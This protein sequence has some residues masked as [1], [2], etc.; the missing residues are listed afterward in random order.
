VYFDH[1]NVLAKG[2]WDPSRAMKVWR[3]KEESLPGSRGVARAALEGASHDELLAELLQT[4]AEDHIADRF[5]VWIESA[6]SA[7]ANDSSS[8]R[9]AVQ[10]RDRQATPAEWARLS[11]EAA[12]PPELL[13]SGKSFDQDL[14]SSSVSPLIGPLVEMRHALWVPVARNGRLRGVLLAATRGKNRGLPRARLEEA[15]AQ[16]ELALELEEQQRIARERSADTSLTRRVLAALS[17]GSSADALLANLAE[18]CTD[19]AASNASIGAVFAVIGV[20]ALSPGENLPEGEMQFRW[21]SGDESWTRALE[22][23]PLAA[24]WRKSLMER[25]VLGCS[26]EASWGNEEVGRVVAIPVETD[27]A[28][29][30]LLVAGLRPGAA[31]LALLERL[32]LSGTLA[33][34]ALAHFTRRQEEKQNANW[35]QALLELGSEAAVLLDSRGQVF[36]MNRAARKLL[37]ES[38]RQEQSGELSSHEGEYFAQLFRARDHEKIK[39]WSQRTLRGAPEGQLPSHNPLEVELSNGTQVR[40]RTATPA[41]PLATVLIEPLAKGNAAQPSSPVAAELQGVIEWLEE[42]VV[43]FDA[44]NNIRAMNTRF[45]QMAGL[46]PDEQQT[47]KTFEEL[48]SRL[49]AQAADPDGLRE[50]WRQL[51][52]GIEGGVREELQL[53]NP[54]PRVLERAARPLLDEAG[55]RLGWMEIYRDLT[56]R[57]IF[58]SK[59]LQTEKLAALGQMVT[60]VA[61]E[62]SNPLTSIL[63]YAQ[64]LL[65][66]QDLAGGS[67]EAGKILQEADRAGAI[68]RQLLLTARDSPPERC[69]VSLNQVVL[70]AAELQRFSLAAEKVRVELDLDPALPMV[71][72]DAGQ[73][74]QVLMNILGNARQ[75]IE[76]QGRGGMIRVRTSSADRRNVNLEVSDDGPGV[77]QAIMARI[78]D[79]FFT[80]KAAGVG[81]GLGLAIVHSIVREHGGRVSVASPPDGGAVF[82]I[83]LPVSSLQTLDTERPAPLAGDSR[84]FHRLAPASGPGDHRP[85]ALPPASL[86]EW[87]GARVLVL[88]DEPTVASLIADVLRDEGLYVDVLLDGR[89]ALARAARQTYTLAICDMKMPGLDGQHF[90]NT[91]VRTGNPLH[92][93]FLFVTGDTLAPQTHQF[94]KQNHVP[95]LAKPFRVEELTE[96][97]RRV[98]GPGAQGS[99]VVAA[100]VKKNAMRNG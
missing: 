47:I 23:E 39:E 66:R 70:R 78:F 75:A 52:R 63:G 45:A 57:R 49:A 6:D 100:A 92:G 59:L 2:T 76:Q 51:S 7:E 12:L 96:S 50:S 11:P 33:G 68:L 27:G 31:S 21:K 36:S 15:A 60:G 25:R 19:T 55:R 9:G 79:P 62:L 56:A 87:R 94:L 16:L 29:I 17:G 82:S 28:A 48:L 89:E 46:A 84:D 71:L 97:V 69:A 43:L 86:A 61:H 67:E 53:V 41:G 99:A 42:G 88:E 1:Q 81:T 3:R 18:N 37:S 32:E 72:G 85:Q 54:S 20:S 58:Q 8:F 95:H 98:L 73:L 74:Q 10:D 91:L 14:E 13:R 34:A 26:P 4:L 93:K 65:L 90:Y 24:L 64:R 35:H 80:T 77:P 38:E 44:G 5:G 83:Q 40:I 22:R 30:G